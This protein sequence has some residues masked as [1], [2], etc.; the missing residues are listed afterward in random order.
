MQKNTYG[1]KWKFS[2]SVET[3]KCRFSFA[4]GHTWVVSSFSPLHFFYFAVGLIIYACKRLVGN[5]TRLITQ[6][7]GSEWGDFDPQK[8]Q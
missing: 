3:L 5:Q 2:D 7:Q 1:L 6:Q 4:A 8:S